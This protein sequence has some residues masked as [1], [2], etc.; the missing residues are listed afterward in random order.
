MSH[1]GSSYR[2]PTSDSASSTPPRPGKPHGG[3]PKNEIGCTILC[4]S[5]KVPITADELWWP[6]IGPVT[7]TR[8]RYSEA[9]MLS[10]SNGRRSMVVEPNE[11]TPAQ[12]Q[13]DIAVEEEEVKAWFDSDEAEP[14]QSV[15]A[16]DP[17]T[18]YAES[19]LRVVR[20]TKDWQLDYLQMALDPRHPL[21]D[22]R[23]S[24]QRRDRWDR[25][26]RSRLVESFLMNI[27]V[28]P[29]F[30]YERNYN[31]YEVIDGRQRL[32][33]LR[34][35]LNNEY[36][37]L[38][39][40]FWSEFD[41]LRFRGLPLVIQKG[42]MRRSL[43]A[44]VLMA[45]TQ[46]V[47][48]SDV[49]VRR[50]LFDR[51]NTGGVKLNPQELRNALYPGPLNRLLITLA[52]D[53]VF[54][55]AWGIPKHE[56]TT[57]ASAEPPDVLLRNPM[58]AQMADVELVL[59]FFALR[60][61][62]IEDRSGSLRS[63]MDKYME[64]NAQLD[65]HQLRVLA[66]D[67]LACLHR[68]DEI[69]EG[70]PFKLPDSTRRSRP[71]YDALMVALSLSSGTMSDAPSIRSRLAASLGQPD[72]YDVLVGRANT[73]KAVRDRVALANQILEG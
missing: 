23:P 26:K 24:Y 73:I 20:E 10:S 64:R 43:P 14:Q 42:L 71:L 18:K 22:L 8:T 33:A 39:L 52:A 1:A 46:H 56:P 38:G 72:T 34:G 9:T 2:K 7:S 30:L 17:A 55:R 57:D 5:T 4:D 63:L 53:P 11:S 50:V 31:E 21:I 16:V 40:E 60:E 35:F 45:E 28:P 48:R 15:R 54:T 69:F 32:E 3:Q 47:S 51:L 27:P 29:I 58:Y 36:A 59:R 12:D 37:L 25:K 19:Q 70:Q 65:E 68:L 6:R 67:F 44:V 41:G 49:D 66:D 62:I 13:T 61:A